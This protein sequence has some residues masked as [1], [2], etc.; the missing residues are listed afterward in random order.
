MGLPGVSV[1]TEEFFDAFES[2]KSAIGLDA[3]AVYVP[4]PMQNK[5]TAELHALAEQS[6]DAILGAIAAGS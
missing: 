3:A 1:L 4:H 5:S 2:Q 6:I